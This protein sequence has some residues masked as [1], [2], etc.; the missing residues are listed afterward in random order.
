MSADDLVTPASLL[1]AGLL[2]T[3]AIQDQIQHPIINHLI[4]GTISNI[5]PW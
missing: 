4:F 2:L 5:Y 1:S 3:K